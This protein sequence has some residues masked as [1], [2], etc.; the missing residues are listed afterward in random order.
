MY[1]YRLQQLFETEESL[2]FLNPLREIHELPP[3]LLGLLLSA[4]SAKVRSTVS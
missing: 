1:L 3:L 4:V 2:Q